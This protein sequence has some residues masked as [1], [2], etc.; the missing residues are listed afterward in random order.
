MCIQDWRLGRLIT[1]VERTV[2]VTGPATVDI[3]RNTQRVL[4]IFSTRDAAIS[5]QIGTEVDGVMQDFLTLGQ[6]VTHF[7]V[8]ARRHGDWPT[9]RFQITIAAG[10]EN[11]TWIEGY[12][13]E[14]Y[15]HVPPGKFDVPAY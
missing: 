14:R 5:I 2:A 1:S 9:H 12:M 3:P 8:N 15:L 13:P 7:E 6:D 11:L 4:L 10:I